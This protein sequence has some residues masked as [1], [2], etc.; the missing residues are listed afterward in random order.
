VDLAAAITAEALSLGFARVAF[1]PVEPLAR[2]ERALADWLAAGMHGDMQYMEKHATRSDPRALLAEARTL[3]VV[4]LPYARDGGALPVADDRA[5]GVVAR[6]ARGADYHVVMKEKL[7]ALAVAVARAAGRPVLSR[8]CVDTAN[9]L[10]REAAHTSGLGFIAKN[11]M[12][13]MPGLGSYVMLGELLVDVELPTGKPMEPRCGEC[14][15]CMSACPTGAIVS[16]QVVDARRCISYLTIELKGAM[17]RELRPLVGTRVFGCDACQEVCPFNHSA[18]P[19]AVAPEMA[20]RA[21]LSAPVLEDLL[22]LNTKQQR[23]LVRGTAWRRVNRVQLARNAAVALGNS[24][25]ARAVPALARALAQDPSPLVRGHAAW[26]LGRLGGEEAQRALEA[27]RV[28]EST[29]VAD[30][31]SAALHGE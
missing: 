17:P 31:V 26:A 25:D 20:P 21:A 22:A 23:K 4:A 8:V 15:A 24:G 16:P 10:E 18:Q 28:D 19:S 5:R 14:T 30:E 27:A 29:F 7:E 9:L 6:Y 11:A 12:L 2:G 1:A 13:I 3:I